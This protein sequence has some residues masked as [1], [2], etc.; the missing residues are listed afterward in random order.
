MPLCQHFSVDCPSRALFDQ[1]ADKW[2][3]MVLTVLENEPVRFNTI[4]RHLE[5]VTQKSLTQCLRRLE[6]NGLVERRV[7]PASPV[8]VEYGLTALGRSLLPPFKALYVWAIDNMDEVDAA[9][10]RFDVRREAAQVGA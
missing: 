3:M 10:S 8:A 2:S 9:R 5:G 1:I 7:I 4:K 6:R